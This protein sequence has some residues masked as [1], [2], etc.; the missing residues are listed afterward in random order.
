[1]GNS[2]P[3]GK[4]LGGVHVNSATYRPGPARAKPAFALLGKRVQKTQQEGARQQPHPGRRGWTSCT[5]LT[6]ME[7]GGS[8]VQRGCSLTADGKSTGCEH[9]LPGGTGWR[10]GCLEE[11]CF[12]LNLLNSIKKPK[13][14]KYTV[15]AL[16]IANPRK[17]H[18]CGH[19]YFPTTIAQYFWSMC[20]FTTLPLLL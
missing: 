17:L 19:S 7:E 15:L 5:L 13:S 8:P 20:S 12:P 2:E 9:H 3:E 4:Q 11:V 16:F 10:P 1:M 18:K 14:P 6:S